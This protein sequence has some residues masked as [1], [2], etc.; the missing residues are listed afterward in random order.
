[1]RP[2]RHTRFVD[3]L[4]ERDAGR[5]GLTPDANAVVVRSVLLQVDGDRDQHVVVGALAQR[6]AFFLA[7]ADH[8]I[9]PAVDANLLAD[10][11]G[12][13]QQVLDD[14]G[15]DDGDLQVIVQVAVVQHAA[16]E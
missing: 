4:V 8:L 13:A 14:V 10:R 9:G 12:A 1:M 3:G 11:I 16:V 5:G 7:D 15:A 6:L 2:Q